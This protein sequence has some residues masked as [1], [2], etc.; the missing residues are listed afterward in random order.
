MKNRTEKPEQLR[1]TLPI[2]QAAKKTGRIGFEFYVIST[3]PRLADKA[4]RQECERVLFQ[5][6]RAQPG[7]VDRNR[8]RSWR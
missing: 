1:R 2:A 7:L 4:L 3:D 8:Q 5:W 6:V